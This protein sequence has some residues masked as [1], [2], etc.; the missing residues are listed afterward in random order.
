MESGW[1]FS[2][3]R[4]GALSSPRFSSDGVWVFGPVPS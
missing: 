2:R 3:M 4:W 1:K